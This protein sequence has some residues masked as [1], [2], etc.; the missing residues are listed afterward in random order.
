MAPTPQPWPVILLVLVGVLDC[1]GTKGLGGGLG[2]AGV[3][4]WS[5]PRPGGL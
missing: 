1:A 5:D 3:A 2:L 4:G